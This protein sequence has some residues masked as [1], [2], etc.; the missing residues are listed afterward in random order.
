M[1]IIAYILFLSPNIQTYLCQEIAK[2]ISKSINSPVSIQSVDISPFKSIILNKLYVADNQNDTLIYVKRLESYIDSINFS[3]KKIFINTLSLDKAYM[4]YYD[5][6]KNIS[7]LDIFINALSKEEKKDTTTTKSSTWYL[8]VSNLKIANSKFAYKTYLAKKKRF[9]MNYDDIL[10]YDLNLK[11]NNI[12]YTGDSLNYYLSQFSCKEKCGFEIKEFTGKQWI[13][14]NQWGL[15]GVNIKSEHSIAKASLLTFNYKSNENTWSNFISKMKIDYRVSSST[16]NFIDISYFNDILEGYKELA[17]VS[18]RVYGTIDNLKGR[19]INIQ[20]GEKTIIKGKFFANGL[21]DIFDTYI[22]ANIEELSTDFRDL[23][24]IYLPHYDKKYIKIPSRLKKVGVFSYMGKFNGFINDFVCYGKILTKAGVLKTDILFKPQSKSQGLIFKG[25]LSARNFRLGDLIMQKNIGRTSFNIHTKGMYKTNNTNGSISGTI[26]EIN[27][28]DYDYKNIKLDGFFSDNFFDGMMSIKDPNIDFNFKGKVDLSTE[29]AKLNFSS[30]LK[31]A[32][33]YALNLNTKDKKSNLSFNINSNF[34]GS[35]PDNANGTIDINSISYHNNKGKFNLNR[36]KLKAQTN[37]H[38]KDIS[39]ESDF[40]RANI[41]GNYKINALSQSLKSIF[42]S[43]IPKYSFGDI[44]ESHKR[45]IDSINDFSFKLEIIKADSIVKVLYP[46]FFIAKN[47]LI[48]GNI[49]TKNK[50]LSLNINS[51]EIII[52]EK[53]LNNINI[54]MKAKDKELEIKSTLSKANI[55]DNY[56][57]YN[58]SNTIKLRENK[59]TCDLLWSNWGDKTYSGYIS[60]LSELSNTNKGTNIWQINIMPSNIIVADT[61]WKIQ[62]STIEIDSSS[63]KINNFS[64]KNSLEK[65]SIDGSISENIEDILKIDIKNINLRNINSIIGLKDFTI[66][67][68]LNSSIKINDYYNEKKY[69]SKLNVDKFIINKDTIGN[70]HLFTKWNEQEQKIALTSIL[71]HKNREEIKITGD[72][73]PSNSIINLNAN[74]K[75]LQLKP[76]ELYLSDKIS[77][78]QGTCSGD[79]NVWGEITK[80]QIKGEIRFNESKFKINQLQTIYACRDTIKIDPKTIIFDKFQLLD[81]NNNK[82]NI[83]GKIKHDNFENI[84]YDLLVRYNNFLSLNTKDNNENMGYGKIFLTGSSHIFGNK[85]LVNVDINAKTNKNSRLFVSLN[86]NSN[87]TER[88]FINF[89]N[90]NKQFKNKIKKHI[91]T[92]GFNLNCDLEINSDTEIQIILNSKIGDILKTK[93]NG[94]INVS[95]NPKGDFKILGDYTVKKGSYL[96]TFQDVINKKFKIEEGGYIKW[97]GN[98][99]DAEINMNAIYSL[100]TSIRELMLITSNIDTKR[101]IPVQCKMALS[102]KLQSP[103]IKFGI[104]FPT[105]DQQTQNLLE[106]LFINDDEIKKQL[107]SLLVLNKFYTPEYLRSSAEYTN[108]SGSNAVGVTSSELLSNQLSNWLSMISNDF[109]IGINYRPGDD[110]STDELEVALSTQIFNNKVTINGN[111]ATGKYESQANNIVGDAD[112]NIKLDKKGK[113][114]LKAFTRANEYLLY[115]NTKN[116]QGLGIFYKE[117]FDTVKELFIKYTNFIRQ[118]KRKKK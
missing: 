80:P 12:R 91:K 57:L 105:L 31:K 19:N 115:Q 58:I 98:P 14:N 29:I 89:V 107:L 32:N 68:N 114:Q 100:K 36:F 43:Y 8:N 101:K 27:I 108:S 118:N 47:S 34:T 16:I 60:T 5:T 86:S 81:V 52:N 72:Y 92:T 71:K 37:P 116:T 10:A 21:P 74:I 64:I 1:P 13:T 11:I 51:D 25:D 50:E 9:G 46:N 41:K 97:N 42:N 117:D 113:L 48:E 44:K 61:T 45:S 7:N 26:K 2:D 109:D 79:I 20:Y 111:V 17:H 33:L 53:K 96:F 38:H 35:G 76:L 23:E 110:I 82:T 93:G 104:D 83:T 73:H 30:S 67:G 99:Y 39:L 24:N 6:N 18:G 78:I 3:R 65:I 59:L 56:H 106:G 90:H 112:I 69:I 88:N 66:K 4:R 103:K 85:E 102:N 70:I 63:V 62:K 22:E 15:S 75:K 49:D 40:I 95:M 55:V 94:I 28:Y 87:V 84:N 54:S 77:Q